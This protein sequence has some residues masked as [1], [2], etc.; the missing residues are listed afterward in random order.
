MR[1]LTITKT[2]QLP[3]KA[4]HFL[5]T[6]DDLYLFWSKV[7]F[8]SGEGCWIWTGTKIN[9]GYGQHRVGKK[10]LLVHRI[11]FLDVGGVINA[12]KILRHSCNTQACLNPAHLTAGTQKENIHDAIRAGRFKWVDGR[13]GA[14][15]RAAKKAG[16]RSA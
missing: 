15:A 2:T 9:T 12:G 11:A 13:L 6:D 16:S 5:K 8:G 1:V 3:I 4:G 14:A 10:K 7:D